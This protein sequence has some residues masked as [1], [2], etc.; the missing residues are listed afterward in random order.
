[1]VNGGAEIYSGNGANNSIIVSGNTNSNSLIVSDTQQGTVGINT[2]NYGTYVDGGML[3][4]GDLGVNG[5]IYSLNPTSNATVNVGNNGMTITGTENTVVLQADNDDLG[6]NARSQLAMSPTSANLFVNTNDGVSHGI[7]I[8]QTSTVIS[9]GTSSTS[10]T[11]DDNGA[12]FTN[13]DTGGP[14][15]VTGVANGVHKYDAVNMGQFR[16]LE[17]RVDKAYSGIAAVSAIAAVPPPVPG[18][19]FSVGLG[20]GNFESTNAIAV[21]AKALVG[22]DKNTTLTVGVGMGEDSTAV[23]AGIGWSF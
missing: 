14:A 16:S 17:N 10:L 9:G 19:N 21:G 23:S 12:T 20:Y 6:T 1:M 7:A 13:D 3:I 4:D 8:S 18:K 2:F 5:S 15:K 11:L 22:E